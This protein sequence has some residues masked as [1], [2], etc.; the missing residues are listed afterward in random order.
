MTDHDFIVGDR[1]RFTMPHLGALRKDGAHGNR[2]ESTRDADFGPD[3]TG[4]VCLLESGLPDGWLAVE[5][6]GRP[7]LYVPVDPRM[8]ERAP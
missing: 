4:R 7:E 5:P 2:F 6:D 8:I 1:V 3:D